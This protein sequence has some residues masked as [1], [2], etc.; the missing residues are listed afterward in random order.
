MP[1]LADQAVGALLALLGVG[2]SVAGLLGLKWYSAGGHAILSR[3]QLWYSAAATWAFGQ[4]L[5][6][7]GAHFA[8]QSV[9]AAVTN[10]GI[11][12]NAIGANR[13]FG[14]TFNNW[15]TIGTIGIILG[16]VLVVL[17][18]PVLLVESMTMGEISAMFGTSPGPLAGL[19]VTATVACG[20]AI[21]V[22]VATRRGWEGRTSLGLAFGTLAG[23]NGSYSI[24]FTKLVWLL[25]AE[26]IRPGGENG[27]AQPAAWV[28]GGFMSGGEAIMIVCLVFGLHRSEASVVV[29]TYYGTMTVFSAVQGILVFDLARELKTASAVHFVSGVIICLAAVVLLGSS[30]RHGELLRAPRVNASTLLRT[31]GMA[32]SAADQAVSRASMVGGN[33]QRGLCHV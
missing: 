31:S 1:G 19:L 30:R 20:A 16:A 17:S 7:F 27:F 6:F 33:N 18:A 21:F 11:V 3:S 4:I 22:V 23:F 2:T 8:T 25:F 14:E 26:T 15:D 13:L 29:P 12:F 9:V 10:M 5:Q 28:L 32:S 24:T